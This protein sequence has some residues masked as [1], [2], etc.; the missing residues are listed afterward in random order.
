[1]TYDG[2]WQAQKLTEAKY[3]ERFAADDAEYARML[4]ALGEALA[5]AEASAAAV[6]RQR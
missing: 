3:A 2:D 1:M 5:K 6:K 4:V